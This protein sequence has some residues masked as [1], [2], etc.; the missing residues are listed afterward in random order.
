MSLFKKI[1][2][3]AKLKYALEAIKFALFTIMMT[4][5]FYLAYAFI[6]N[7]FSI[8]LTNLVL[9]IC[10]GLAAVSEFLYI[11]WISN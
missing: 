8:E 2:W 10:F 6:A 1:N 7:A 5:G 3:K 11:K 9:W 4:L